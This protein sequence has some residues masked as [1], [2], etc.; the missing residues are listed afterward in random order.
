M[1]KRPGKR[2]LYIELP[3]EFVDRVEALA[4][5]NHR[6]LTGE[7]TLAL[8]NHLAKHEQGEEATTPAKPKRKGK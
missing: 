8:E 2:V 3:E 7:V 6:T 5:R 4:D 1:P